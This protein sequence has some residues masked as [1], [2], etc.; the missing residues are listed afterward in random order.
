MDTV[1]EILSGDRDPT[2]SSVGSP[3]M[4]SWTPAVKELAMKEAHGLDVKL[5]ELVQSCGGT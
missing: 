1:H 3:A 4:T 5:K 2:H